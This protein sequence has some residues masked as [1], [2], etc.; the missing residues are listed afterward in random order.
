VG[1]TKEEIRLET[2][3]MRDYVGDGGTDI[4]DDDG[5]D[6]PVDRETPPAKLKV[7]V[8]WGDITKVDGD[9]YCVGHY[10]GVLPQNAELSLDAALSGQDRKD[11]E[12]HIL[13]AHTLR[14]SLRG[15]LGDVDYFPWRVE[16]RGKQREKNRIVAVAGMGRPGLF[17]DA[18]LR[19][20]IAELARGIA[21]FPHVREVCTVL[22]G[23][24]EGTLSIR[25]SVRGLLLGLGDA[26]AEGIDAS[27]IRTLRLVELQHDRAQEILQELQEAR[28]D[29]DVSDRV[30][31]EVRNR[32]RRRPGAQ[33]SGGAALG[34]LLDSL[35]GAA[36]KTTPRS[37]RRLFNR[38]LEFA[39]DAAVKPEDLRKTLTALAEAR[40][41]SRKESRPFNF[42]VSVDED[43]PAREEEDPT[44]ISF[45]KDGRAIR[46]AALSKAATIAERVLR[47]DTTL[48]DDA[49]KQVYLG[50]S[51]TV[52]DVGDFLIRLL[53][54]KDFR[55]LLEA[56]KSIVFDVDREM[57]QI[58]WEMLASSTD[59]RRSKEPLGVRCRVARQLRT[60][61][62]APPSP[63]DSRRAV[64]RALVIGDPGDPK[65]GHNLP[66][67]MQEALKVYESLTS[68][69]V[70]VEVDVR[71]GAPGAPRP[72]DLQGIRPA[73]RAEVLHLLMKGGYDILHYSG[74]GDFDEDDPDQVGWVFEDGLLTAREL[75]RI[76]RSPTLVVANACLS[77]RTSRRLEG[78][79]SLRRDES[80]TRRIVTDSALLPSLADEFFRRGVRHYIGTAWP[81]SD[82]GAILFAE[83]FYEHLLGGPSHPVG[84]AVRQARKA[85]HDQERLYGKL[86]AAYQHYG[87]PTSPLRLTQATLG[88]AAGRLSPGTGPR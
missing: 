2:L 72:M 37:T 28:E 7:E 66:G 78:G 56:G 12:R 19:V 65:R 80:E 26:L 34:R 60:A 79:R 40:E 82:I 41:E 24:G 3:L 38:I 47:A 81:V 85:L 18:E 48:V 42:R 71:I 14:G 64:H 11:R 52:L 62:S 63:P 27:R 13:R 77:A 36:E 87:D 10:E 5:D 83:T 4:W 9:A 54:P 84:E 17:G 69:E 30:A 16:G 58:H 31:L 22:I 33:V 44:Y 21:G 1:P 46:V 86:W 76:D 74:H 51:K 88:K 59:P 45:R 73:R 39:S 43:R 67:A 53:L 35:M 20:L 75:E 23:S 49:V 61:Y 29:S 50:E 70:E 32:V 25:D 8:I 6:G 57:A 15:S 68:Q 55:A